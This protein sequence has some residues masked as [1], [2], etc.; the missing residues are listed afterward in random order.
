M[1]YDVFKVLLDA[2]YQYLL[3]ILL[4]MFIGDIG[5]KFSFIMCL[6]GFGSRVILA[7]QKVFGS[8]PFS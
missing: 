1:M 3:R 5:L 2:V 7:P 6:S 4:S 8:L